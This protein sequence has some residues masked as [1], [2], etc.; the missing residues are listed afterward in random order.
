MSQSQE[1]GPRPRRRQLGGRDRGFELWVAAQAFARNLDKPISEMIHQ[2]AEDLDDSD[3]SVETLIKTAEGLQ[4]K[5]EAILAQEACILQ[6]PNG[7]S[8]PNAL[9]CLL[10]LRT[11]KLAAAK[12]KVPAPQV[13]PESVSVEDVFSL[14]DEEE[15]A[16]DKKLRN[17]LALYREHILRS[18]SLPILP[19]ACPELGVIFIATARFTLEDDGSAWNYN[20][21]NANSDVMFNDQPDVLAAG[22]PLKTDQEA[23][24]GWISLP[25][26]APLLRKGRCTGKFRIYAAKFVR[27]VVL[28]LWYHGAPK[29]DVLKFDHT[30]DATGFFRQL[31]KESP[32]GSGKYVNVGNQQ[33]FGPTDFRYLKQK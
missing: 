30:L 21:K 18:A 5:H 27:G 12:S 1:V 7:F 13:A 28:H 16:Q 26:Y 25:T 15:T 29:T 8:N 4:K 2:L 20:G 17:E 31:R 32:L 22:I 11:R 3:H 23:F 6:L 19:H 33:H 10:P 9:Q 14:L 24:D